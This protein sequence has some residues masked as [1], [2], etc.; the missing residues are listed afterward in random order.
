MQQALNG[1]KNPK[2]APSAELT[3]LEAGRSKALKGSTHHKL[4]PGAELTVQG[5]DLSSALKGLTHHKLAPGADGSMNDFYNPATIFVS[6][7]S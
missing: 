7:P 4:V 2:L 3:E 1:Y 5:A 6:S